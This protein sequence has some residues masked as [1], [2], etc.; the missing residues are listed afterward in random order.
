MSLFFMSDAVA[1]GSQSSQQDTFFPLI[2]LVAVF[3]SFY[4]IVI[5][6]Q[7]KRRNEQQQ[8]LDKLKKG[9]EITTISGIIGKVIDFDDQFV[10]LS[11]A[12]ETEIMIQK[13]AVQSVLPKG[14]LKS[15]I[16]KQG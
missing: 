12:K 2:M 3:V 7:N 5:R 9:D 16:G 4:F 14:T 15:M 11:V 10:K 8:L 6:P 1:A 13:I